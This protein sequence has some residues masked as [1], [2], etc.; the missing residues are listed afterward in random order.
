M[1]ENN[2][3]VHGTHESGVIHGD[4]LYLCASP[5]ERRRFLE[6]PDLYAP[7]LNGRDVVLAVDQNQLVPGQRKF[8]WRYEKDNRIYLFSSHG[9]AGPVRPGPGA[10]TSPP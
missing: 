6:H 1:V 10:I 9:L 8:G 7:V 4:R 2:R 3:W 5:E